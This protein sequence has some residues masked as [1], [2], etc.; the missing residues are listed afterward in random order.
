MGRLLFIAL[1]VAA[2]A[3]CPS[4]PGPSGALDGGRDAGTPSM[5]APSGADSGSADAG[6][7]AATA[8]ADALDARVAPTDAPFSIPDVAL[9]D[10]T[11]SLPDAPFA[12]PDSPFSLPDAR[13]GFDVGMD[14]R[15]GTACPPGL[16]CC[17]GSGRCY[18]PA[19]LSCCM[20]F[21]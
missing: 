8:P 1:A 7:D 3:G 12:L 18:D 11:F 16:E 13:F 14:C 21:P 15:L 9:P 20:G 4:N 19:C 2:S 17:F 5:D 6:S 10:A